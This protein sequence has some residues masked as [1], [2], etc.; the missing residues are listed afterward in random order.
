MAD[1]IELTIRPERDYRLAFGF[2][3]AVM[4]SGDSIRAA[5][6]QWFTETDGDN[7]LAA[8]VVRLTTMVGTLSEDLAKA[9][10]ELEPLR[11]ANILLIQTCA[12]LSTLLQKPK[13]Y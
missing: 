7:D 11:D 3:E 6:D 13:G 8:E 9:R 1:I 4:V 12:N 5:L 2:N 10:E